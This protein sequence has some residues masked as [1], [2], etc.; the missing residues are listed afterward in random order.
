[1]KTALYS[2]V[3]LPNIPEH[4]LDFPIGK[5]SF[6][7]YP[8]KDYNLIKNKEPVVACRYT[9]EAITHN[10]PLLFWLE[11]NLPWSINLIKKIQIAKSENEKGS[12][13]AIHSDI[14]RRWALNYMT[15]LGGD[16]VWTTWYREINKPIYRFK[17]HGQPSDTGPVR[18]EK[19]TELASVKLENRK[20][21]LLR[22]D[23]LHDVHII[24]TERKS[25][26]ISFTDDNLPLELIKKIKNTQEIETFL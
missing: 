5:N 18:Y 21:Y 16:D 20:W 8:S 26:T 7:K 3:D 19:L 11:K 12:T 17:I 9:V 25:I 6:S 14:N 23:I 10:H 13:H 1:M 15:D 2:E 4:L 24:K 22:V